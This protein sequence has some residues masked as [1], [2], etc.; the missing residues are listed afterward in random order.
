MKSIYLLL[1]CCIM[2]GVAQAQA[3]SINTDGS[4]PHSSAILD[5]KSTSKGLLIPRMTVQ[6][7]RAI[8]N[9]TYGLLV[10]QYTGDLL[11][12]GAIGFYYRS[13]SGW[14]RVSASDEQLWQRSGNNQFSST[15]N[16]GI[17]INNPQSPLH[18]QAPNAAAAIQV[19]GSTPSMYLYDGNPITGFKYTGHFGADVN[20]LR[21][22]ASHLGNYRIQFFTGGQLRA[23]FDQDGVF[24]S[25]GEISLTTP[26]FV[27]KGFMQLSGNNLRVGTY[28][29]NTD[30]KFIA[31]VGGGDRFTVTGEGRIGINTTS[32]VAD[33][34]IMSTGSGADGLRLDAT[35]PT[36]EFFTGATQ[37]GSIQMVGTTMNIRA[38]N[39][40]VRLGNEVYIEEANNR[41]GIGTSSPTEKLHV[42]GNAKVST[43][44]ILNN[45][46]E[47]LMPIGFASYNGNGTKRGGTANMD[48][49]WIG[50]DFFLAIPGVNLN[51]ATI[52][53]TCRNSNLTPAWT[54]SSNNRIQI[55]F[56]NNDN[57]PRIPTGFTVVVYKED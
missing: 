5:L 40:H 50:N 33:L 28:S 8:V 52:I 10:Y 32:P 45:A 11:P 35:T 2:A 42:A 46:N 29:T 27:E 55:N 6:Q 48:G 23:R 56:Y 7:R 24:R 20:G 22:F 17:G 37:K 26:T 15:A 36:L 4:L 44:K 54:F 53:V 18:I 34:H 57:D 19:H 30:G 49:G 41:V 38:F 16:V 43:G 1:G 31:R 12:D 9:P 14:H 3:V 21:L 13:A 39:G 25:T 47:N 51:D